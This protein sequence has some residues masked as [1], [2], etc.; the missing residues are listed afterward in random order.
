MGGWYPPSDSN[1]GERGP[2]GRGAPAEPTQARKLGL[3]ASQH[4]PG[5]FT[6]TR[7]ARGSERAQW[8]VSRFHPKERKAR[9]LQPGGNALLGPPASEAGRPAPRAH[10]RPR[11]APAPTARSGARTRATHSGTRAQGRAPPAGRTHLA[12]ASARPGRRPRGPGAQ[13]HA[14]GPHGGAAGTCPAGRRGAARGNGGAARSAPRAVSTARVR[15]GTK[16]GREAAASRH[17]TRISPPRPASGLRGRPGRGCRTALAGG[18][19]APSDPSYGLG[20]GLAL[21][22]FQASPSTRPGA[23]RNQGGFG[24]FT[25]RPFSSKTC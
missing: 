14:A 22:G 20:K 24:A 18:L 25:S 6:S 13:P 16:A 5:A 7:N 11:G 17:L 9:R 12:P 4:L 21:L 3:S 19:P 8:P 1:P 2:A 23:S 15:P 10:A